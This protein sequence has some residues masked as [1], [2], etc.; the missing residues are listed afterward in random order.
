MFSVRVDLSPH[1]ELLLFLVDGIQS[2]SARTFTNCHIKDKAITKPF[3]YAF[4]IVSL[5]NLQKK[6]GKW[7]MAEKKRQP[8]KQS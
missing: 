8:W 6:N 5:E 4:P 7:Q 3:P 1:S 2:N